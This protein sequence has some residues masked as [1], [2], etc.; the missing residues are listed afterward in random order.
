MRK[1]LRL[2]IF[3]MTTSSVGLALAVLAYALI[4]PQSV[5]AAHRAAGNGALSGRVIGPDD[6]PVPHAGVI[7]QSSAGMKV[8]IVHAD[9][10]GRFHIT[11]L[12]TDNYEV[13]AISKGLFSE[14]MHNVQVT[15]GRE[16]SIDLRLEYTKSVLPQVSSKGKA[17]SRP[18]SLNKSIPH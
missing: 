5:L 12:K 16:R 1:K 7:Y 14:W 4:Y 13:R 9:S 18:S 6:R 8:H 2:P 3:L 11:K 17:G 10:Q 15:A